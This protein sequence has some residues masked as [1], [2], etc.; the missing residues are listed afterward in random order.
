MDAV[1]LGMAK[2]DAAR[3]YAPIGQGGVPRFGRQDT[4]VVTNFE[5]GHGWTVQSAG[6]GTS[7]L[8]DTTDFAF[9][10]QSIRLTTAGAGAS[11]IVPPICRSVR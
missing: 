2:A 10:T 9:G 5:S 7:N 3:K 1:T 4:T 6:G 11:V 8:N